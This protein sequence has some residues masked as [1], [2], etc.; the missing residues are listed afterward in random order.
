M[1]FFLLIFFT[2]ICNADTFSQ[3]I[4]SWKQLSSK[5]LQ[6][7]QKNNLQMYSNY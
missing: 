4:Y 3:T 7:L 1:D 6:N 5:K 2:H